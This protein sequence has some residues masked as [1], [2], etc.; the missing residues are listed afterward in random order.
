MN[1]YFGAQPVFPYQRDQYRPFFE[2][3]SGLGDRCLDGSDPV[4]RHMSTADVAR[5]MDLLRQAVGDAKLTYLGFSYGSYLGNTYANMF[6]KNVR[7][8]VIDGV[9]DP[10]LWSSG[11]QIVSDRVATEEEF[12]EFLRLCD[13][14]GPDCAFAAP[15]GSR[16]R[17]EALAEA[18]RAQPLDLGEGFIYTYDF[19][20]RRRRVRDVRAGDLGRTGRLRRVLRLP[21]RRGAGRPG[22]GGQR[23]TRAGIADRSVEAGAAR[24]ARLRQRSRRLLRQPVRGHA[25]PP[26]VGGVPADGP[27]RRGRLAFGPYWW[28]FNAGCADWP[29]ARDRYAGPWTARTSAPVLVVGNYFDGVTDYA[30]A[31]ASAGC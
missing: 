17:W 6:P 13:E 19:L 29:V 18:I 9:L 28:W 1:E 15:E 2:A 25:V 21:R 23:P 7:A 31:Q 8:L 30:G 5:D 20:D 10:R 14:A 26:L 22:R 11:F 3:Y 27:L 12:G 24:R 4:A 16:A